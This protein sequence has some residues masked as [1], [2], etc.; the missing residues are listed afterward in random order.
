MIGLGIIGAG[1]IFQ[2][3]ISALSTK[4]KRLTVSAV[5]DSDST[6]LAQAKE[7]LARTGASGNVRFCQSIEELSKRD[8]DAV[9]IATPPKTHYQIAAVC[10]K[11]GISVL[12]EKPAVLSANDLLS[13]YENANDLLSLYEKA[14]RTRTLLHVA[15][16]AAFAVDL[17]WWVQQQARITEQYALGS[18]SEIIC[19]F[20]VSQLSSVKITS[21]LPS[22]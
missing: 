12:L 20:Y 16:H 17:L 14:S 18:L 6:R 11:K 5:C 2:H 4:P 13:L 1:T 22:L 10:L 8:C 7:L 19:G 9:L 21:L 3:Q 15:Y